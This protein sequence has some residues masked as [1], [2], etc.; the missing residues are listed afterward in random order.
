ML[1]QTEPFSAYL[2]LVIYRNQA[3]GLLCTARSFTACR[4]FRKRQ[5]YLQMC[6][7]H[8]SIAYLAKGAVLYVEVIQIF[9]VEDIGGCLGEMEE[10]TLRRGTKNPHISKRTALLSSN[11]LI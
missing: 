8:N 5:Y 2:C 4:V 1:K 6:R 3:A 7:A 10:G 11:Y 9:I